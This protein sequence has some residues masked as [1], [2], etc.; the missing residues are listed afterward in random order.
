MST[1]LD[2]EVPCPC[3]L[4]REEQDNDRP[5]GLLYLSGP[6]KGLPENNYPAFYE[7]EK[8]ALDEGWDVVNPAALDDADQSIDPDGEDAD[9]K[10]AQRDL[11]ALLE[12]CTHIAMLPGWEGS[13][14]ARAERAV[15]EWIGIP[16]L[17]AYSLQPLDE[18]LNVGPIKTPDWFSAPLPDHRLKEITLTT[19]HKNAPDP[20]IRT[21][22]TGATRDLDNSK[23]QYARF[24]DP[25]VVKSYAEYMQK[26]RLQKDGSIR[27]GDNWKKGFTYQSYMDSLWRHLHRVWEL[28]EWH[29]GDGESCE[30]DL[31]DALNALI[32]NASGYLYRLLTEDLTKPDRHDKVKD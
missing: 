12:D 26:N 30:D 18:E 14:G 29:L 5:L 4:C 20:F 22:D 13:K 2:D 15:A 1:Y 3:D 27:A 16:I 11:G 31:Q 8:K 17:D 7:A 9:R 19:N 32:F 28:H 25:L 24:M 21:F 10:Y 23:L 6:M